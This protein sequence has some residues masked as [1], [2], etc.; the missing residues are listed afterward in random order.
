MP[1]EATAP[2]TEGSHY[3]LSNIRASGIRSGQYALVYGATGA[4]GSSAVQLLKYFGVYVTAVCN[5]KN[6]QLIKSLGA[7]EVIDYQTR[8]FTTTATRF[9]LVFD[10]VGKSSFG[11]CKPLMNNK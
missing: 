8:D 10:A 2:A 11:Q 9:D 3:A 5:T 4:I 6:V 7:D 1:Y